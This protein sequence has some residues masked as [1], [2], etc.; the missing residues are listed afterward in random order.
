MKIFGLF[1]TLIFFY[2]LFSARTHASTQYRIYGMATMECGEVIH[3]FTGPAGDLAMLSY[4]GGYVSGLNAALPNNDDISN[5]EDMDNL[6]KMIRVTC[7]AHKMLNFEK[8]IK[9][10]LG[11]IQQQSSE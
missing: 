11:R 3:T 6:V 5:S 9:T 7:K 2:G 10:V 1:I 4:I 8:A